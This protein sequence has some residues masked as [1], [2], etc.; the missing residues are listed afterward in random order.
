MAGAK[1]DCCF[2]QV[3]SRPEYQPAMQ[4]DLKLLDSETQDDREV[5]MGASLL[6]RYTGARD[7]FLAAVRAS[8][9]RYGFSHLFAVTDQ[10]VEDVILRS[11]RRL[12]V[13][14]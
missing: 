11:L 12:G 14:R 2:L 9:H 10:S 4:G 5:T 7:E 1:G 8:C 13:I 3:F 6:R